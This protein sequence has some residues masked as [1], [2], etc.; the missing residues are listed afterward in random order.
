MS[1]CGQID[2]RGILKT[3]GLFQEF[4]NEISGNSIPGLM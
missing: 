2:R 1:R 3:M 4:G